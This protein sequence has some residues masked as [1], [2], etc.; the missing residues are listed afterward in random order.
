M[1]TWWRG[2]SLR[3][4]LTLTT[5]AALAVALAAGAMLLHATLNRSLIR[6]LDSTASQ[7]A[8]EVAALADHGNLPDPVPMHL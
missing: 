3:A 2:R 6:G 1:R 5:T 4:R 8:R 7:G